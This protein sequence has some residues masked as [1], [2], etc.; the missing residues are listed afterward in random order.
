MDKLK[1]SLW[2]ATLV[3]AF[4]IGYELSDGHIHSVSTNTSH[5]DT[6]S[7]PQT[8][9]QNSEQEVLPWA[10]QTRPETLSVQKTPTQI[11][12]AL[13]QH[14]KQ[15]N[16]G[17]V[18]ELL[19][20]DMLQ[21]FNEDELLMVSQSLFAYRQN[22]AFRKSLSTVIEAYTALSPEA[23]MHF[24]LANIQKNSLR[25]RMIK[26]VLEEW[27]SIEPQVAFEWYQQQP[28]SLKS[29]IDNG[30]AIVVSGLAAENIEFAIRQLN[31]L[32]DEEEIKQAI[33]DVSYAL[34]DSE[35]FGA[36]LAHTRQYDHKYI[37]WATV[38]QWLR[39]DKSELLHWFSGLTDIEYRSR[40]RD[41]IFSVWK[42]DE[43]G[44]SADWLL[45]T[46]HAETIEKDVKDILSTW[47][48][49]NPASALEWIN[50][51]TD[52]DRQYAVGDLLLS[53]AYPDPEF[54]INNLDLVLDEDKKITISYL[55]YSGL[56]EVSDARASVF[57]QT[58]P[59]KKQIEKFLD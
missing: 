53:S 35:H 51:Q 14:F 58:S 7:E 21:S 31:K 43:P 6:N 10:I 13:Y 55:V 25:S 56:L 4:F 16:A 1:F 34:E 54:T 23:A 17:L 8:A 36:L 12:E 33:W 5:I 49:D 59:Y 22:R 15:E 46:S 18:T 27:A 41:T 50:R 44:Q 32:S 24:V 47:S 30:Y 57:L 26:L 19:A 39:H 45:S 20:Y 40:M 29:Q 48:Y 3:A 2:S 9:I 52:I 37:D 38:S 28:N 11:A 42:N